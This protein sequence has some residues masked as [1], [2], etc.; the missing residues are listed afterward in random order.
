MTA[1]GVESST[2]WDILMH[3]LQ[4]DDAQIFVC[5]I[6]SLWQL[7]PH[8][9]LAGRTHHKTLSLL[10]TYNIALIRETIR[11]T[12]AH[13]VVTTES[14]A[15]RLRRE[16][17]EVGI[18]DQVQ[19]WILVSEDDATSIQQSANPGIKDTNKK[20]DKI[21]WTRN[22]VVQH[23][24]SSE[25]SDFYRLMYA[26]MRSVVDAVVCESASWEQIPFVTRDDIADIAASREWYILDED[27]PL[28]QPTSGTSGKGVMLLPRGFAHGGVHDPLHDAPYKHHSPKK[29]AVYFSD[30]PYLA[31]VLKDLFGA[32]LVALDTHDPEGSARLVNDIQPDT[33]GGYVYA[34]ETL[35]H[36]LKQ[37][38]RAL[39]R[40]VHVFGERPSNM[41]WE[42]MRTA[43]P[44]AR[45]VTRY[46]CMES[47]SRI[48]NGCATLI[49][50]G[51]QYIHPCTTAVYTEVIDPDTGE[52]LAEE[53]AE[54]E[55]VITT[56][57]P[58]AI[59]LIRYRTN[60]R[61]RIVPNQCGCDRV[62]YEVLGR[63]QQT[64]VRFGG[65]EI[66]S[67]AIE[68]A[69]HAVHTSL[70]SLTYEAHYTEK[71]HNGT[72]VPEL[73]LHVQCIDDRD[74]IL[75][76]TQ[77]IARMLQVA[78]QDTYQDAVASGKLLPL[79]IVAL[80]TDYVPRKNKGIQRYEV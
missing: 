23:G 38:V 5:A 59:P 21:S 79:K 30:Q 77:R 27:I 78:P 63:L 4:H 56:L 3:A 70:S 67:A 43:F 32:S 42:R 33:L 6:P 55:M 20:G 54:G 8:I 49:E 29:F 15:S 51:T 46:G 24:L 1:E 68:R 74:A 11:Q 53:G 58:V 61:V 50:Q 40:T 25:M 48:G 47:P 12:G 14:I 7:G 64:S 9:F 36:K 69:M 44:N 76:L 57:E 18:Y 73:T 52:V 39:V 66:N 16:L 22:E 34:L 60:D 35:I 37:D 41:Q 17:E 2:T 62:T 10:P 26:P 65:G 13:T 45:I 75:K 19:N 72:L 71:E 31:H 80:P 28:L